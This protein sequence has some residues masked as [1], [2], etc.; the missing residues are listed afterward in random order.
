MTSTGT[1]TDLDGHG[2]S[3]ATIEN[4]IASKDQPAQGSSA[5][6]LESRIKRRR[7]ELV[8]KLGQI[9]SDVRIEAAEN[10]E[11]LKTMLSELAHILTWGTVD[12]WASVGD[13]V[14]QRLEEWLADSSRPLAT[15][16]VRP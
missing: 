13:P 12:D 5:S 14:A 9:R 16:H 15:K 3:E 10:R 8:V 6:D 11:R 2:K 1:P 7:I 4:P